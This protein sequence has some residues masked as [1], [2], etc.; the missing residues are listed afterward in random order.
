MG[1]RPAPR[2][3]AIAAFAILLNA[4]RAVAAERTESEVKAE[5][6]ERFIR[7]V[8]WG[9]L[10]DTMTI[11]VVG[12]SAITPHLK[13]IARRQSIKGRPARVVS[14]EPAQVVECQVVMIAGDDSDALQEV[15]GRTKRRPI[16]TIAE[17]D[18]AAAAGAIINFYLDAQ[19]IRF[20]I[21]TSAAKQ[22]GLTLRSKLLS[23]ARIISAGKATP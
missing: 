23:L 6:I 8:D 13:K 3:L 22:S 21:N 10:P 9:R 19:H 4:G 16:L 12:D 1:R 14:V 5:L 7:F 11:C 2:A 17:A 15:I 20:E 18:G